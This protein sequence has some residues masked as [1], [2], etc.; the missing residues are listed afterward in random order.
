MPAP[1][2]AESPRDGPDWAVMLR[3]LAAIGALGTAF[4]L[5]ALVTTER[6]GGTGPV[7]WTIEAIGVAVVVVLV[8]GH[9]RLP[10]WTGDICGA[11][12]TLIVGLVIMTYADPSSP[13]AFVYLWLTVHSFYFLPWRRAALQL[14]LIVAD[15]AVTLALLAGPFPLARWSLTV[16]TAIVVST[17]VALLRARVNALVQVLGATARTDPL[18][19]LGNRR[20]FD[21]LLDVEVARAERND[22]VVALILGDLD[23]FKAVNDRFGHPEG[24][25]VLRRVATQLTSTGRRAERAWRLGGDEFALVLPG[26]GV[27]GAYLVG[28]RMRLAIAAEFES[29]P[30]ALTISLGIACLPAHGED[31]QS[32]VLAADAALLAAKASGR[33]RCVVAGASGAAARLVTSVDPSVQVNGRPQRSE[34]RRYPVPIVLGQQGL[35]TGQRT[36]FD[37]ILG[38]ETGPDSS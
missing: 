14:A 16:M 27:D 37:A 5:V 17:M 18:T 4:L 7:L 30:F 28:E 23:G 19:G 24:D 33:N 1:A 11:L 12:L 32:L 9:H 22:Q 31:S 15:Y 25:S 8:V 26:A 6:P 3:T 21:E 2:H 13:A 36:A 29:D 34:R 20:A 38:P 10:P 35:A